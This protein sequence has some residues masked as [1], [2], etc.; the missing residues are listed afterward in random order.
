[1]RA[2]GDPAFTP[3]DKHRM[4]N[5]ALLGKLLSCLSASAEAKAICFDIPVLELDIFCLEH[6]ISLSGVPAAG[7]ASSAQLAFGAGRAP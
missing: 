1:M 7:G 3:P 4:A 5:T 2:A 6:E